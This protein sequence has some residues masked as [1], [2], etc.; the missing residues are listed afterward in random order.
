MTFSKLKCN[1][2]NNRTKSEMR[3]KLTIITQEI[4]SG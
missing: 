1:D 2:K 4:T 3:S